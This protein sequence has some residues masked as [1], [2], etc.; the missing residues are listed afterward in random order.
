MPSDRA[1]S[2]ELLYFDS[3][4]NWVRTRD[5]VEEVT[6]V[7]PRLRLVE[8][9]EEADALGFA[10]SPTLLVDGVDP[11]ADQAGPPGLACRTYRT[12]EGGLSE[13]PT[14]DMVRAALAQPA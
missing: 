3:C 11:W 13:G 5:V 6:G 9:H 7:P 12:P 4:P 14:D 8:T 2:V 1:L 10:G